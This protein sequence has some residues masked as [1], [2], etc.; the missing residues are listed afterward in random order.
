M[1]KASLIVFVPASSKEMS[2][3]MKLLHNLMIQSFKTF[4]WR[5]MFHFSVV[6]PLIVY[7]IPTSSVLKWYTSIFSLCVRLLLLHQRRKKSSRSVYNC[8]YFLLLSKVSS[9][10][11]LYLNS[12]ELIFNAD[13]I[14]SRPYNMLHDTDK[15]QLNTKDNW[16]ASAKYSVCRCVS[17]CLVIC[18]AIDT[19]Q[20]NRLYKR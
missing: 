9:K 19:L 13:E 10:V 18:L 6:G 11:H 16:L 3:K 15:I 4:K 12:L 17:N 20:E 7:S 14:R 1:L 5:M 2:N 8:S